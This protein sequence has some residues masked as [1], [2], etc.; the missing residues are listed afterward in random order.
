M[1]KV[2]KTKKIIV[3]HVEDI[4]D[5]IYKTNGNIFGVTFVK[6]STGELRDITARLGVTS[7]LKGGQLPFD[8]YEKGLVIVFDVQKEGYRSISIDGII[9]ARIEGQEYFYEERYL[10]YLEADDKW[11]A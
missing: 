4:V 10:E 6:R 9:S 3:K 5:K 2:K 11:T 7:H 8:P 1:A